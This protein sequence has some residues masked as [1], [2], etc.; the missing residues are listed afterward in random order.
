MHAKSIHDSHKKS[1]AAQNQT[2]ATCCVAIC[3]PDVGIGMSLKVVDDLS[4][5]M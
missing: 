3:A 1:N 5:P 4:Q 2:I